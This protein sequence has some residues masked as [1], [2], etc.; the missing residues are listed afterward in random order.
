MSVK[1]NFR[2]KLK[3]L[4]KDW[5]RNKLTEEEA[6]KELK[7]YGLYANNIH[8]LKLILLT[9]IKSRALKRMGKAALKQNA[10]LPLFPLWKTWRRRKIYSKRLNDVSFIRIKYW[11]EHLTYQDI[12]QNWQTIEVK[13]GNSSVRTYNTL[14]SQANLIKEIKNE[15]FE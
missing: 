2:R 6:L 11:E 5:Q 4:Y 1:Y 9:D 15:R 3:F 12:V 13:T 7:H 14:F 8:E 10:Y